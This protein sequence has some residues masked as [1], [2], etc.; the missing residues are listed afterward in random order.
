MCHR[1]VMNSPRARYALKW[2]EARKKREKSANAI[3]SRIALHAYAVVFDHVTNT[4]PASRNTA[5]RSVM[6]LPGAS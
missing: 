2:R 6:E 5:S 4:S 1:G 3:G